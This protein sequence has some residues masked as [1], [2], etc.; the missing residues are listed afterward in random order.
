MAVS[1]TEIIQVWM[2][3][4]VRSKLQTW[5]TSENFDN[6]QYYFSEPNIKYYW[7]NLTSA[8]IF[9]LTTEY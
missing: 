6:L 9:D 5:V 3:G 8:K 4:K 2:A 1:A 7:L